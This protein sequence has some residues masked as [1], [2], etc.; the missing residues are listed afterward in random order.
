MYEDHKVQLP[1]TAVA[2]NQTCVVHVCR[3]NQIN[4][5]KRS[6]AGTLC[7]GFWLGTLVNTKKLNSKP[8]KLHNMQMPS[9]LEKSV[10]VWELKL[11]GRRLTLQGQPVPVCSQPLPGEAD[12]HCSSLHRNHAHS[13]GQLLQNEATSIRVSG[14]FASVTVTVPF[15]TS[16]CVLQGACGAVLRWGWLT[17]FRA[18]LSA[19]SG[20]YHT[21]RGTLLWALLQNS[22]FLSFLLN[23]SSF[24][25]PLS[26][27]THL[28]PVQ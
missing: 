22:Q 18:R 4:P 20:L 21:N 28:L 1:Q 27:L 7:C 23:T 12:S 2:A 11:T 24:S 3:W 13:P 19:S 16:V 10:T 9:E 15:C 6:E 5:A 25:T 17:C 14:L 8:L 26:L